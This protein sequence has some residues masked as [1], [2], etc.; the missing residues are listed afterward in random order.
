LDLTDD[1]IRAIARAYSLGYEDAC[2][3][4]EAGDPE[5]AALFE[6]ASRGEG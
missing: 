2:E 6:L 4:V 3:D 5:T 1:L